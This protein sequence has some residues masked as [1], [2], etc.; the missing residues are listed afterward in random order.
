MGDGLATEDE[1][2]GHITGH[3]PVCVS[4]FGILCDTENNEGVCKIYRDYLTKPEDSAIDRMVELVGVDRFRQV[5]TRVGS[6]GQ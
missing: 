3:C 2:A 5:A 6:R 1:R 4:A